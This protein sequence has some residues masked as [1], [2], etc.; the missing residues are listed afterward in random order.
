MITISSSSSSSSSEIS[1]GCGG[2]IICVGW[3][4][5]TAAAL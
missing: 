4:V 1:S 5:C 2:K 3:V